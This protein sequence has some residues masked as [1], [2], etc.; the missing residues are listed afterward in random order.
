MNKKQIALI[1][2][3]FFSFLF[4]A[5]NNDFSLD[6]HADE[7]KKVGFIANGHQDFKQ[8]LLLLQ[9]PRLLHHF[10]PCDITT[11]ARFLSAV[12]GTGLVLVTFLIAKRF[13]KNRW[14]FAASAIVAFSPIVTIHAHYIKEDVLF[15]FSLLL[16]LW[17]ALRYSETKNL[18]DFVGL[19]LFIGL[20][21]ST[22]YVGVILLPAA[23]IL[24]FINEQNFKKI[25]L[26]TLLSTAAF[27]LINYPL[28][29]HFTDF[30]EAVL[31]EINHALEGHKHRDIRVP[32]YVDEYWFGFHFLHSLIPGFTPF[33]TLTATLWLILRMRKWP[34]LGWPERFLIGCPLIFYA[35]VELSPLKIFPDFMRYILP[36]VPFLAIFSASLWKKLSHPVV[37]AVF[38]LG[39]TYMVWDS[40]HLIYYLNK[41]TRL[42]AK[43]WISNHPG[44]CHGDQYASMIRGT[45]CISTLDLKKAQEN[46]IEYLMASSFFYER[47]NFASNLKQKPA[48]IIESKET[49]DRLFSRPYLEIRPVY[50]SFAYSNPTIRIIHLT[51]GP[52]APPPS[53]WLIAAK[54]GFR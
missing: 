44:K 22:K 2:L 48:I 31:F 28:F 8:P 24:L 36:I 5:A 17:A 51:H 41:D 53:G 21:T 4:N 39:L 18:K 1:L 37:H 34:V 13:L 43:E 15:T 7:H 49:Y 52:A 42:Q 47:V 3:L 23:L 26:L 10:F 45:T 50:K 35:I 6:Y 9:I 54:Q 40:S 20:A 38:A 46:G 12:Y 14:A 32:V 33:F 25:I 27:C 11:L 19:G 29:F 30:K 16:T